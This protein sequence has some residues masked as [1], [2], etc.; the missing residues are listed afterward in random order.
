MLLN[1]TS[2]GS[3]GLL[4]NYYKPPPALFWSFTNSINDEAAILKYIFFGASTVV[5]PIFLP[6][7][8]TKLIL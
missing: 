2:T 4:S 1:N 3:V 7:A 6:K 5:K 8:N